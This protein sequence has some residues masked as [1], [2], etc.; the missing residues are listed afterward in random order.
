MAAPK[1]PRKPTFSDPIVKKAYDTAKR[2][3]SRAKEKL[4][5]DREVSGR[6]ALREK[7]PRDTLAMRHAGVASGLF[8]RLKAVMLSYGYNVPVRAIKAKRP[9]AWTDFGSITVKYNEE[10][11]TLAEQGATANL[12]ALRQLAGETRGLFHHE[13]G[14]IRFTVPFKTL[15]EM[16]GQ[17]LPSVPGSK[18]ALHHAWNIL[19][20]Q[21]MESAVVEESPHIASY[22]TV[23]VLRLIATEDR[24]GLNYPLLAGRWYLPA[25]VVQESAR[26][27][28]VLNGQDQADAVRDC[29]D[30][31][32]SATDAE[33][34]VAEVFEMNRLTQGEALPGF[35]DHQGLAESDDEDSGNPQ[36]KLRNSVTSLDDHDDEPEPALPADDE[37]E[38]KEDEGD[39]SGSGSGEDEGDSKPEKD[40]DGAGSNNSDSDSKDDS[41]SA[42]TGQDESKGGEPQD[43]VQDALDKALDDWE[44]DQTLTS[45]VASINEASKHGDTLPYYQHVKVSK[46]DETNATARRLSIEIT[47]AFRTAT[48][49]SAPLWVGQQRQGVLDVLR[50]TTRQAGDMEVFRRYQE[51]GDPGANLKVTVHLDVSVSMEGTGEALGGAAWAVKKAGTD[52]NI[53]TEVYVF[54]S[55]AHAI[56]LSK[57]TPDYIPNIEATGGTNPTDLFAATLSD[58]AEQEQ[59]LVLI[60]TDAAWGDAQKKLLSRYA[61]EGRT[62]VLFMYDQYERNLD[63]ESKAQR[64][65]GLVLNYNVD[66]AHMIDDLFEIPRI[67]ENLLVRNARKGR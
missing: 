36:E 2:D 61:C 59:H 38:K 11:V 6:M 52:L 20:D 47:E 45:D 22:L 60:M 13:L 21:R 27:Y 31:Y 37:D 64:E 3:I 56:Y 8:A 30:R 18:A 10:L 24:L 14:H 25:D 4:N 51:Y 67:L 19:E 42:E 15:T 41:K 66:E 29:I 54:N 32:M 1:N 57:D 28:A 9:G 34:M 35:D 5:K 65:A 49:D 23:L 33:S 39:T 26:R 63:A 48:A 46:N 43:R 58:E 16:A 44:K 40:E 62:I 55:D 7:Q 50:Y 17:P 53:E 12:T